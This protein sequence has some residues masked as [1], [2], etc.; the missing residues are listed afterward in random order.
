MEALN[1]LKNESSDQET[2]EVSLLVCARSCMCTRTQTWTESRYLTDKTDRTESLL[3][4]YTRAYVAR[5]Y[6][7][8]YIHTHLFEIINQQTR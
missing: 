1:A 8:T 4:I 6:I 3:C 2:K 5:T 7:H